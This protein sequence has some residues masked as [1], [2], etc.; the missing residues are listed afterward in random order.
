MTNGR[1]VL[2]GVLV[3]LTLDAQPLGSDLKIT[4]GTQQDFVFPA[5]A[6]DA[7]GDFVVAW[8]G[9][10]GSGHGEVFAQRFG[11][12]AL[13]IGTYF[14]VNSYTT[15]SLENARVAMNASGKFVVVWD[16]A[17]PRDG[18]GTG[19]FGQLFDASG[20]RVGGEF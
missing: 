18:N 7:K 15:V 1:V 20:A 9:V 8:G 19:I 5:V 4:P 12:T 16:N 14:R 3:S 10:A 13:P 11:P 17:R 2:L 6:C